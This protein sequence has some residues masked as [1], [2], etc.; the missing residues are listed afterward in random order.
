M[1]R[2]MFTWAQP[3][4]RYFKYYKDLEENMKTLKSLSEDLSIQKEDIEQG[5]R[6]KQV[7]QREAGAWL[8]DVEKIQSE[9][10][11]IQQ[12]V[13]EKKRISRI[14]LGKL[15]E[16]KTIA[17]K[18]LLKRGSVYESQEKCFKY[19][20]LGG[21]VSAGYAAREFARQGL[22]KGELAIIS[23][24]AVAPYERPAL[25][26]AYLFPKQPARL[27]GFHV[28]V[29]S[30]G[31]RLL[32]EWYREKG[33]TLYL[34]TE[35]VSADLAS[36]ALT[37][38]SGRVFK[39]QKLIIA[40]GSTV[41]RLSD[42]M[43]GAD[44]K[45]VFYLREI[46][47]AD[48]LVKAVKSKRK[49]KA[50]LVGAGYISLEVGA[51]LRLNN[52]DVTMVYPKNFCM[53]RLFTPEIATFYED[54]YTN[55]GV[56][57]VKGTSVAG[58]NKNPSNDD[59]IKEVRL[60]NGKVLQAD[61]VVVGIGAMPITALFKGQVQEEKGGI[62]TDAFF[63]TS[64]AGVYAVG[65]V[66]TFPAIRYGDT[67]RVGSVDHARKSAEQAVKAI[68]A[69]ED[70]EAVREYDYMPYFYSR[71]FDLS[72]KFYGDNVG[73]SVVFGDKNA[74][75]KEPKFGSYWVHNGRVKGAF[76]EGGSD[77]ENQAIANVARLQPSVGDKEQLA[78]EGL[79]FALNI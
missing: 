15:V 30:G 59:E 35:I 2:K 71:V 22:K 72:W 19:V 58:F 73:E 4:N 66:S 54:Y 78:K 52:F 51:A 64:I 60:K 14:C 17:A 75:S 55:K 3:V 46:A 62:K 32:R 57:L 24:E 70:G 38:S 31:E 23:R 63:R 13:G 39:F 11:E 79:S 5:L 16:E 40:T 34:G 28:C 48:K 69:G 49:G 65:D 47:D 9:V 20:I 44:A 37:T 10:E 67:R 77:E 41:V 42:E 33:I 74:L 50:V 43:E 29:G 68:R 1:I 76:L 56:K 12:K 27:P 53:P 18:E 61:I 7:P 45:N 36:K 8:K 21:G 6:D 25:S 26:K